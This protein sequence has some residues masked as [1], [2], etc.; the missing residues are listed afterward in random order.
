MRALPPIKGGGFVRWMEWGW[1]GGRKSRIFDQIIRTE[2][3]I[4]IFY[5][6]PSL[7]GSLLQ[8]GKNGH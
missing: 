6:D 7:L 4:P 8:R 3:G 1:L 5:T 2:E